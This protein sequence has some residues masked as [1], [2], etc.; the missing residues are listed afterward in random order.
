M[1]EDLK[2]VASENTEP[3]EMQSANVSEV[4][5]QQPVGEENVDLNNMGLKELVDLFQELLEGEDVLQVLPEAVRERVASEDVPRDVGV[6]ELGHLVLYDVADPAHMRAR[7]GF[8]SVKGLH[9]D[10]G[11]VIRPP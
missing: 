8:C 6:P 10:G 7:V 9:G 11:E 3:V 2:P 4:T 5:A 1:S